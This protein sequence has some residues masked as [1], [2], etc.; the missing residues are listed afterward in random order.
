MTYH[1]DPVVDLLC[2][3]WM[4]YVK[5]AE[6]Y[7]ER[8]QYGEDIVQQAYIYLTTVALP[9]AYA[10]GYAIDH[11]DYF[12][13]RQLRRTWYRMNRIKKSSLT[14]QAF[15][16]D[17]QE[18]NFEPF[19][20]NEGEKNY[21][22]DFDKAIHWC[23]KNCNR[24]HVRMILMSYM[25]YTNEEIAAELGLSPATISGLKEKLH[26]RIKLEYMD[27]KERTRD[28]PVLAGLT[29]KQIHEIKDELDA[30]EYG[31]ATKVANKWNVS[32]ATVHKIRNMERSDVSNLRR[33]D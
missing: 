31:I 13:R 9:S 10:K 33:R 12:I 18:H 8:R 27:P 26:R 24:K 21:W 28:K 22:V 2:T 29:Q 20:F 5:L 19:S 6:L 11:P 17:L 3:D 30:G 7:S 16:G 15:L 1:P 14:E 25:G 4:K 23:L 32:Q